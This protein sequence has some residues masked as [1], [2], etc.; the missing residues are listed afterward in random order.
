MSGIRSP[1]PP[2]RRFHFNP[3]I[4]V[5]FGDEIWNLNLFLR[6]KVRSSWACVCAKAMS[7]CAYVRKRQNQHGAQHERSAREGGQCWVIAF[8]MKEPRTSD[9][10]LDIFACLSPFSP[11]P[12]APDPPNLRDDA[13]T[14]SLPAIAHWK[15]LRLHLQNLYLISPKS[16]PD[17]PILDR[18][19]GWMTQNM[20]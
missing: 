20:W 9:Q 8:L 12:P 5:N 13:A 19:G 17:L 6:E 18:N 3:K 7:F 2:V 14:P 15:Y 16:V 10:F 4:S 1:I 11:S